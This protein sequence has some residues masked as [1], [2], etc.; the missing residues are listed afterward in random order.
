MSFTAR[1]LAM[2]LDTARQVASAHHDAVLAA[3]QLVDEQRQLAAANADAAQAL[4]W[5]LDLLRNA[6]ER[7][8]AEF[9]TLADDFADRGSDEAF[10]IARTYWCCEESLRDLLKE[11]P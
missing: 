2:Q 9:A 4:Q 11:Q 8:A 10:A 1:E 7:L 3:M 5:K 6:V